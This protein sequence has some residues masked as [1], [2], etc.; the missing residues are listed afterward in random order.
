MKVSII[1]A[2]FNREKT[3]STAIESVINQDYDKIEY[4]IIDGDSKDSSM[5]VVY[6]YKNSIDVIISEKDA[7]IYN[8]LNKGI[9]NS[10]GDIIGILHS[11][12]FF[13]DKNTITKIVEIFKNTNADIVYANGMYVDENNIEKVKRIYRSNIFRSYFLYFGWIP[14]HTTIFVKKSV[15]EKFDFYREDFKIAS[16]YEISLR[17]FRN[18]TLKK[19]FLNEWVVKMRL[20]G[21]STDMKQQKL[22]SSEDLKIIN[23]YGLLGK[24]TLCF[25]ILRKV[26]QYLL[27]L[28]FKY[29]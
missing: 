10:H 27:P 9:T 6:Q 20:G 8:A 5:E 13:Y 1:T 19:V 23:E 22:K 12:D 16:D 28:I 14:L 2:C 17:W 24:L 26:P 11:D 4:L 7:G 3:I 15:F 29:K 21:K 25:K 18:K